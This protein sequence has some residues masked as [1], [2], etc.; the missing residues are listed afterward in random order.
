MTP[1]P[2]DPSTVPEAGG[3]GSKEP[4]SEKVRD[5]VPNLPL[6]SDSKSEE[7]I[8]AGEGVPLNKEP[9]PDAES[10]PAVPAEI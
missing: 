6:P 8:A 2:I 5:L 9:T 10:I 1:G 7:A 3:S 4:I